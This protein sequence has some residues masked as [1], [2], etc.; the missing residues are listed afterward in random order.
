M[1]R[2][3]SLKD[4]DIAELFS[5]HDP[6]K[7]FEDLREI[8]HGSFGAV[9]YARCNLTKEIV[10]IKKM[11]YV[12]KQSEEKW[13]DILKE[14]KFLKQLDHPNTIEYKGCYKREHT[15]WLV[16]EYCVGS[17]SDII[18]V[19]KRPLREEE[20]A[21]ICEGVVSGLSYLHSLG[22]IHR[23][24]KAG[25]ILLTENGTVKLADFGSASIKCPANSFVGTPYWMAPEVILAMDEGQYDGKVDVWSL[26]IT[27]IELAERKPPYFNMNAMSALYHIAQN[28]SPTLQVSYLQAPEWTDT[29]RYFVEACLRKN[30]QERPSS[31]G[32]LSHIFITR[33]RSPNV[34]VDLIQRTKAAVRDLDNL[35]YRKMKKILMV[36][37]DNESAIGD[38]EETAEERS[39]GDSSKSNSATSEHSA[40]GASSQSS[41]SGSL[42][43]RP[44]PMNANHHGQHQQQPQYQH[45]NHQHSSH[46]ARESESPLAGSHDDYVN[47]DA[48]R[49]YANRDSLYDDYGDDYANRDAIREARERDRERERHANEYREYVNASAAWQQD[50]GDDNRNTQRRQTNNS[51]SNNV[52]AAMSLVSEHGANNFATIRTTSIVTQQ[53]KEH[54]QEMHEQMSGYKRM[55]REHQAALF[56]LEERCKADV[57][58][59]K[60]QLDREYEALLQQLSRELERLQTKHAQELERKQKQ[61]AATEKKLIKDITTRQEQERK[62]FEAQRKREYKANKERWKKELSM[63]DATPKRQ[64]DATLQSQ[65]DNL[66]QA[67]AAE[68]AR[69]VRSQREYLELELRRFRRRRMLAIHHKEQELLREELNKR[70]NQLEQAHAMLLRHHEKTQELEYRQQKGVHALREEQLSNQHATELANQREYMQRAEHELRKK[71]A[72]QL[73][74][75]PKSLKQKEMQIRKQFRETCK[76]Q[77]RQYKALKAQIL[78]MTAKEQQKEVIKSLKDEKRRKLVLLG[79]QY[80]QS[81]TEMLQKQ[82]VR[83]DESQMMECQQLKMQ[84]EHEL[85]MLTAYQSKSKMQAEAQRNRERRE[86]EDRVAVRRGLLEQKMESECAQFVAER[87]ERTRLLH[88][89]H[90]R[91]L[92]HFDNESARLGFSAMAIAEGSRDGYGEEEQSLSGSMLSLA[93][94]NSSASFAAGSL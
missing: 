44:H 56:K 81:I 43:R 31:M 40:A 91:E 46:S 57:D 86:L 25:N 36:D 9:Y 24:I 63:D 35:N 64:R 60:A 49:D 59:H 33:S 92:E 27:C 94:S 83:L 58:A 72:L 75:Q 61:N 18:E 41:S 66:K 21:A 3:G 2:P 67:E 39:G 7:I 89:R 82:T 90:E 5:R 69:L 30:P 87:A 19:H 48:V 68:E 84:L 51:I 6:E 77:T 14:I 13:Q 45:M 34:L 62:A 32:L 15:A 1:P 50:A 10:A 26:G 8:G 71:H 22:R 73:K 37:G 65:K 53:Q 80:D 78:Q 38:S 74:Q 17:A 55:R 42:R 20:I 93:H 28:D 11:S 47:R 16:M 54:N 4:P 12:G 70:Q 29:F 85:D 52:S 88:D 76:I 79:E 23:D